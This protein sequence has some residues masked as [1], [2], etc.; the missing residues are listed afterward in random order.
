MRENRTQGSEGGAPGNRCSYPNRKA[1]IVLGVFTLNMCA[2]AQLENG[3]HV[4]WYKAGAN[5]YNL[6][7]SPGPNI[8]AGAFIHEGKIVTSNNS[9]GLGYAGSNFSF[10]SNPDDDQ[11]WCG[12]FFSDDLCNPANA[13][14]TV[15]SAFLR[16][17]YDDWPSANGPLCNGGPV[18]IRCG[19][20]DVSFGILMWGGAASMP[21]DAVWADLDPMNTLSYALTIVG[22]EEVIN[23]TA[24]QGRTDGAS[25]P[26]LDGQFLELDVTDQVNWILANASASAQYAIVALSDVGVGSTGKA[27]I[28]AAENGV[29]SPTHGAAVP[30]APWTTDGNTAHLVCVGNLAQ[31]STE[32]GAGVSASTV[33]IEN[34]P[35][36]FNPTTNILYNTL[37]NTGILKIFNAEGKVVYSNTVSGK[38]SL[39]WNAAN[40]P[41]G[42]YFSKLIVGKRNVTKRMILIK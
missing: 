30:N 38:G 22:A 4:Y 16:G 24:P 7:A 2:F 10:G 42:M 18:A 5:G 25:A 17:E 20:V 9:S 36:P 21:D 31:V 13:G 3:T 15:T 14:G 40:Q 27:S 26:L 34:N 12:A 19:V 35:N 8:A 23:F 37:G 29:Y 32:D 33:S 1:L 11:G 6:Q 39:I 28:I 41:S